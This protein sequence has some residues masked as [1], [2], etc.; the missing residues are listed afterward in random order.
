MKFIVSLITIVSLS[1]TTQAQQNNCNCCTEQHQQF[2]FWIGEWNTY[3]TNGKLAG[4]NSIT[5]IQDQ[6]ILKE[7]WTSANAGYT[8]TSYNFYNVQKKQWEQIWIDNQGQSLHLRGHF[9]NN[10]MILSSE[11]MKDAKGQ[12]VYNRIT[13]T[14]NDDGTVRQHW[15]TS[16]DQKSW[17]T[18]FDGLY[19]KK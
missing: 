11:A 10:Q 19:K 6:C 7:E 2:D 8:G 17:K 9:K 1:M 13:W 16:P 5:K 18:A 3:T 15:E 14:K 4:T 12:T